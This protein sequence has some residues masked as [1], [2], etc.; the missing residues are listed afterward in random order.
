M[1][2]E[3]SPERQVSEY[4]GLRTQR[5]GT[6][7]GGALGCGKKASESTGVRRA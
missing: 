7:G 5:H 6:E 1:K 2:E 3:R 4:Q